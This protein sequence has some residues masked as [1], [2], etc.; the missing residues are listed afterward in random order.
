MPQSKAPKPTLLVKAPDTK[1]VVP[2]EDHEI[3]ISCRISKR[4][5]RLVELSVDEAKKRLPLK[6]KTDYYRWSIEHGLKVMI[7]DLKNDRISAFHEQLENHRELLREQNLRR[8]VLGQMDDIRKEVALLESLNAQSEI[9]KFL[10]KEYRSIM[11]YPVT[12]W[13]NRVREQFET[14]YKD[15]IKRDR[16][17]VGPSDAE[18]EEE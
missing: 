13:T 15:R 12:F 11:A 5:L 10:R 4:V 9:P 2:D 17:S 8:Q 1:Y 18:D 14:E 7:P 16:I 3:M 6:T